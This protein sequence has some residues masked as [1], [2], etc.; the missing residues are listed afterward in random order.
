M[1]AQETT[2][3]MDDAALMQSALAPEPV[4]EEPAPA[5]EQPQE[6]PRD[7]HGRFAPKTEAK[8]EP[9]VPAQPEQP[10]QPQ[11]PTD[12][13]KSGQVP[14]WRLREVREARE[15]AER[16]AEQEAQQRY[17]LQQQLQQMQRQM[18]TLQKPKQEPVN[19]Y[20]NP[21]GALDQRLQPV[22]ERM[23][24]FESRMRYNMSRVMAIATHGAGLV[25]ETEQAVEKAT[26][27]N[28]PDVPM[29]VAQ[30]RASDDPVGVAVQWHKRSKLLTETGGDLSSYRQ[31]IL[32][33]AM[34]DPAY[35]AKVLEAARGQAT[36]Q[37]T[38]PS[39]QLPPS[40]S[41]AA[42]TGATEPVGLSDADMSDAALYAHATAR[43]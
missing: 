43:R 20:D 39:V 13:D 18:E 16:R 32:D 22:E 15:A 7:E 40:L 33:E 36:Q 38:R 31:K 37:Q 23:S 11:Q 24:Q 30:L 2:V 29:L 34:K 6:Q 26:R 28:H 27:E 1:A 5:P 14:S 10:P 19:F 3:P 4:R 17:A 12:D 41:R 21:D 25:A 8:V 42:G 35:Q 9:E